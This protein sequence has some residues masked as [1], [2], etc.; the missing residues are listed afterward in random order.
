VAAGQEETAHLIVQRMQRREP[1]PTFRQKG[2]ER[3]FSL[4]FSFNRSVDNTIKSAA[5]MLEKLKPDQPQA[6][7]VLKTAKKQF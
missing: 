5:T 3:Q 2:N 4:E 6:A 7:A 1:D